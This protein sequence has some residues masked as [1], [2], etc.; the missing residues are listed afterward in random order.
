[1][2]DRFP[3]FA[4]TTGRANCT[5]AA[6]RTCDPCRWATPRRRDPDVAEGGWPWL[7]RTSSPAAAPCRGCSISPTA[8]RPTRSCK[9]SLPPIS[10]A[11][12]KYCG[13]R[14]VSHAYD[15]L[16][17][18]NGDRRLL[19]RQYPIQSVQS[20]RYRPVT[21]LKVINNN[22]VLNQQA[23]VQVTST[24]LQLLADRRPASPTTETLLT[25]AAY[26]TLNALANAVTALGN[27]WAAQIVGDAG[28][29]GDYGLWP[30]ADLYVAGSYGD[31][32]EG[33][34]VQ[35]SQGNL[36][37][38]GQNAELKMHTYELAGYQWDAR[39][40]LL[41]AIPYTDPE[42]LHPED[43]IWPV[44]V[45]NF[46]VQYTAGYSTIPEAVQEACARWVAIAY[47]L[48]LR[49]PALAEP[50][51]VGAISQTWRPTCST[52]NRRRPPSA[53]G[54]L[55]APHGRQRP[56]MIPSYADPFLSPSPLWGRGGVRGRW[57]VVNFHPSSPALAPQ[58]GGGKRSPN[59]GEP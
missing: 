30:S 36:T 11:I 53:A 34:G 7:T 39:G 10:D 21:V 55:P 17:N 41:R 28:P 6:K 35:T 4:F 27:G 32:L 38:R 8:R 9:R 16:Y 33:A 47:N 20:V 45:N 12:E 1:M 14:F 3:G 5:A 2:C 59:A 48:T 26:P 22:T 51:R 15:E 37:A 58:G 57:L 25:W 52:S 24:G 54:A 23:R 40:W 19:L 50:G 31:P 43:L 49:D 13:R 44:G 42:L 18:G 29:T 46:R 56:G